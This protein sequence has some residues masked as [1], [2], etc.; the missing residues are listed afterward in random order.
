MSTDLVAALRLLISGD[1]ASAVAALD[2]VAG[3]TDAVGAKTDEMKAKQAATAAQLNTSTKQATAGLALMGLGVGVVVGGLALMADK[4][5]QVMAATVQ[6]EELTGMHAQAASE[7]NGQFEALGGTVDQVAKQLKTYD[8]TYV[9][10][11]DSTRKASAA[12]T[13][14]LNDMGLTAAQLKAAGPDKALFLIRDALSQIKDPA[15]RATDAMTIFGAR[16]ATNPAFERWVTAAPSQIKAIDDELAKSGMIV[17]DAQVAPGQAAGRGLEALKTDMTGVAVQGMEALAPMFIALDHA[18]EPIV[19]AF[20]W[21]TKETHG[22]LPDVILLAGGATLMA[23]GFA[24]VVNAWQS[25]S[26]AGATLQQFIQLLTRR[27]TADTVATEI[28]TRVTQANTAAKKS[29]ATAAETEDAALE[30]NDAALAEN[31]AAIATNTADLE[32]NDA[33]RAGGGLAG[34]S[35]DLGAVGTGAAGVGEAGAG[36]GGGAMAGAIAA[37]IV[38]GVLAGM[39]VQSHSNDFAGMSQAE[40]NQTL[41][42]QQA[43]S[44]PLHIVA[45]HM[46]SGGLVKKSTEGT[47]VVVGEGRDEAVVP[48][49]GAGAGETH[50]HLHMEGANLYGT[51]SAATLRAWSPA[52]MQVLGE[53]WYNVRKGAGH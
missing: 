5:K 31:D 46:A 43:T 8:K 12:Q 35:E 10:L 3:A 45:P 40:I 52:L 1:S 27:K 11:T 33:A 34:A 7:L 30:S 29:N 24:K 37:P 44:H 49:G 50:L 53:A 16:A 21:L 36:M 6:T 22:L 42:A 26:K 18:V 23:A 32:A 51:P 9:D 28:Q 25:A 39:L 20:M 2:E 14:A 4:Y 41:R 19:N 13:E 47:L 48:A 17:T 38:A 15:E